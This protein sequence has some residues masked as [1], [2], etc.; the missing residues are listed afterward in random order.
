MD[1]I[2]ERAA[3]WGIETEYWDGLG[4]HRIVEPA[5]LGRL[6]EILATNGGPAPR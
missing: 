2:E 1:G 4:R 5:V 3:R 6:L